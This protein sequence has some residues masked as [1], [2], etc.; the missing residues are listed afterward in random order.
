MSVPSREANAATAKQPTSLQIA[1]TME[2]IIEKNIFQQAGHVRGE[3]EFEM[4]AG[5]WSLACL[6]IGNLFIDPQKY[7][8]AARFKDQ[9]YRVYL[10]FCTKNKVRHRI[11]FY[12]A[13]SHLSFVIEPTT[14]YDH[15]KTGFPLD[16]QT[17]PDSRSSAFDSITHHI[18][19]SRRWY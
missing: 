15:A 13:Q 19:L 16:A 4:T 11:D 5:E 8:Q 7:L 14:W 6:Y 3:I 9:C 18:D 17:S 10:M 1:N 2:T 12:P